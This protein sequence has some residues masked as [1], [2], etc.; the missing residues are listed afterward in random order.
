MWLARIDSRGVSADDRTKL[1]P[2]AARG[3]K[4]LRVRV[5]RGLDAGASC[6]PAD[7]APVAVGTAADNALVL[8]DATVSRYHLELRLV[9]GGVLVEDLGSSNGTWA[10]GMRIE[11]GVVPPSTRLELGATTLVLE[12]E[13]ESADSPGAPEPPARI[14]ELVGESAAIRE[15]T[16]LVHRLAKAT[17]PVLIQGETGT[18]KE[19]VARAIHDAGPWRQAPF[20]VVDCGSMPA[21]LVTSQLFGHEQGAFTGADQRRIGAFERARGGTLLLD[22]IGE[23]PLDVQPVLLGVLERRTFTRLGGTAD[24]KVEARVLSA[25]HRDLREAVN[26]GT[27]RADLYYRLAV[28]RIVVP[29]LRERPEDVPPLV[30]H[31]VEQVVGVPGTDPLAGAMDALQRHRWSGNVRELR[32]VVEAALVMGQVALEGDAP[33]APAAAGA[34]EGEF[35][36]PYGEA[37]AEALR[38]FEAEYLGRL[39][40][41]C[42]G[43]ASEA[44]RRARMDR[45]YL[46]SLL[47][48]HGLR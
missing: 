10:A 27:F 8:S 20:V 25:T 2:R 43:N 11:R 21:T 35:A 36:L 47:R 46:L 12:D 22:E 14:P 7:D 1:Q 4:R 41:A 48:R 3:W 5:E 16:R 39:I 29:P 30:R 38:K 34:D 9:P 32:N 45:P 33:L 6:A 31:F 17:S 15:V 37:R 40:A 26:Q 23:L 13:G 18:G 28:A 44:A 24:I 19:V 42:E